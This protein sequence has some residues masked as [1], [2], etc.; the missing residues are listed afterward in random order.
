MTLTVLIDQCVLVG[1]ALALAA[2]GLL[3]A[4]RLTPSGP[5]RV[6]SAIVIAASLAVAQMMILGLAGWDGSRLALA[7]TAV[8]IWAIIRAVLGRADVPLFEEVASAVARSSRLVLVLTGVVA[9]VLTATAVFAIRHPVQGI[10]ALNYHVPEA[11]AFLRAGSGGPLSSVHEVLPTFP[12]TGYYPVTNEVLIAWSLGLS[13][14][15]VPL[16]LIT[17]FQLTILVGAGWVGLRRLGV[18][19]FLAFL[20]VAAFC[21]SPDLSF[22]QG[23][24]PDTDLPTMMWLTVAGALGVSARRQPTLLAPA[25]LSIALALGTKTTAVVTAVAMLAAGLFL[26]RAEL[27]RHARLLGLAAAVGLLVGGYWYL[28]NLVVH[29]SPAWPFVSVPWGSK[30]PAGLMLRT[31]LQVPGSMV[32]QF[33]GQYLHHF[34]ADFL[35]LAAGLVAA[36]LSRRRSVLLV[37]GVGVIGLLAWVN[38]PAT[39][40]AEFRGLNLVGIPVS[41]LRYLF[42]AVAAGLVALLLAARERR[43]QVAAGAVLVVA[44]VVAIYRDNQYAG[45]PNGLTILLGI[46]AGVAAGLLIRRASARGLLAS[47]ALIGVVGAVSAAA[48]AGGF[49]YRHAHSGDVDAALVSYFAAQPQFQ[50]GTTITMLSALDAVLAGGRLQNRLLPFSSV[51]G[52]ARLRRDSARG[53]VVTNRFF[54]A[55]TSFAQTCLTGSRPVSVGPSYVVY[56]PHR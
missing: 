39:G 3:I 30:L 5:E 33:G 47:G 25:L 45:F 24:G 34:E 15:L 29:G 13:G 6:L 14:T 46:L 31:F 53:W 41:T 8:A 12:V 44:V 7:L 56:P 10:D 50:K 36:V 18:G 16:A 42:P 22:S 21:L 20:A 26:F 40:G 19:A 17:P 38:A 43:A 23:T 55:D 11:L 28:R 1:V 49:V 48:S 51:D 54:A 4:S 9:G 35:I 27:R 32:S 37:A 52:C 2:S